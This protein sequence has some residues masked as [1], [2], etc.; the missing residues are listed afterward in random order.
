MPNMSDQSRAMIP[1]CAVAAKLAVIAKTGLE[2]VITD[3]RPISREAKSFP[4]ISYHQFSRL[5]DICCIA[6]ILREFPMSSLREDEIGRFLELQSF[7]FELESRC[8]DEA[9]FE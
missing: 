9:G 5:I 4:K 8:L 6:N 1:A 3:H 2:E 7:F